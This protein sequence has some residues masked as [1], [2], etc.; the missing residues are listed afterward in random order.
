M[1]QL[2]T[3]LLVAFAFD[4]HREQDGSML[5]LVTLLLVAFAF[6]RHREVWV[7]V[8]ILCTVLHSKTTTWACTCLASIALGWIH[9]ATGHIASSF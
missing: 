4:R 1:L 7:T 3:L 9:V 6:D 2:V 5:Q 8:R